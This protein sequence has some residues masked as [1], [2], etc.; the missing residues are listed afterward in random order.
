MSMLLPMN[1]ATRVTLAIVGGLLLG[2]CLS[3]AAD[4]TALGSNEGGL[5]LIGA[6]IG[7]G[8]LVASRV[9]PDNR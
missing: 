9:P 3:L 2:F 7:V 8:L 6:G 5:G 1:V 4:D